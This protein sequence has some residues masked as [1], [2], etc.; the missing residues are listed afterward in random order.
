MYKIKE[1]ENSLDIFNKNKKSRTKDN[2]LKS[3]TRW[4][5]SISTIVGYLM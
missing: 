3:D 2:I 1:Q 4:D 5:I